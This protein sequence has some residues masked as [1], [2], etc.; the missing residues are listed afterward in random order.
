VDPVAR[1]AG[2]VL[3]RGGPVSRPHRPLARARTGERLAVLRAGDRVV[4]TGYVEDAIGDAY[5]RSAS[6]VALSGVAALP[7]Y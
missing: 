7:Y 1:V 2:R 6:L 5:R 3:H 4:V